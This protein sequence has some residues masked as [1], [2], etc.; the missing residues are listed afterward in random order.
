MMEVPRGNA[1][2]NISN[3]SS[4]N[5]KAITRVSDQSCQSGPLGAVGWVI[6]TTSLCHALT[7]LLGSLLSC[8]YRLDTPVHLSLICMLQTQ[9]G[10]TPGALREF[11]AANDLREHPLYSKTGF[12]QFRVTNQAS[13]GGSLF[14]FICS[15]TQPTLTLKPLPCLHS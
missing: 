8:H 6:P 1:A 15:V 10:L 5:T 11:Q 2:G 13:R 7:C 3:N 12:A 9:V 14:S 4:G